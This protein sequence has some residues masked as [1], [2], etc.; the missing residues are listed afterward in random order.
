MVLPVLVQ[1]AV[2]FASDQHEAATIS[3]PGQMVDADALLVV[4]F[5][6][7]ASCIE[8][9]RSSGESPW[10]LTEQFR[11]TLRRQ[12]LLPSN[13]LSDLPLAKRSGGTHG[14]KAQ[15]EQGSSFLKKGTKKLLLSSVREGRIGRAHQ[16]SKSFLFLFSKKKYFLPRL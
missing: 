5:A 13:S 6:P 2:E 7:H 12:A 11:E 16:K 8:S 10:C 1:T 14:W 4:R 9:T 3:N 15:L